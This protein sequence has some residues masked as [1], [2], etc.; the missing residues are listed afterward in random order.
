MQPEIYREMAAHEDRHW[1][2]VGRRAVL[3][4][5]LDRAQ[6]PDAPAILEVGCGTGGNLPILASRGRTYA[7][8]PH[9][10]AREI[11]SSRHTQVEIRDGE[12]P[13]RLPFDPQSFDLVAALDVL[14]HVEDDAGALQSLVSLAR[15]GGSI[16]VTVPAHQILWGT[17]DIR[18]NHRRRYSWASLLALC[19]RTDTELVYS[20]AF[21][22][23]LAPFA[24]MLRLAERLPGVAIGNQERLP[25]PLVNGV[26]S[27]MFAAER[28]VVQRSRLS[29]GLSL[30]VLLR[31]RETN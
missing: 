14:E 6:L 2:F 13:D 15:P 22:T 7:F 9:V 3:G 21:N 5:V 12:L 27:G 29:F 18:L 28:H 8:D 10:E 30:A 1:W 16:V 24:V 19:E 26:L 23:F 20:T 4:A 25:V 11:A 17:H 31:R